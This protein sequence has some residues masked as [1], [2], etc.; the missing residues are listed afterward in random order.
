MPPERKHK[1]MIS[2]GITNVTDLSEQ[3]DEWQ[4]PSVPNPGDLLSSKT[5]EARYYEVVKVVYAHGSQ[6]L[7]LLVRSAGPQRA[8]HQGLG[9]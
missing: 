5:G 8:Y 9:G 3:F 1:D 7:E 6:T 2:F 4:L